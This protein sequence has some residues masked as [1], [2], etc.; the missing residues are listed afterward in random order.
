VLGA[1]GFHRI[2]YVCDGYVEF[3]RVFEDKQIFPTLITIPCVEK[4]MGGEWSSFFS[5]LSVERLYMRSWR[6]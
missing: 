4:N 5:C 6:N 1:M 3:S 2:G